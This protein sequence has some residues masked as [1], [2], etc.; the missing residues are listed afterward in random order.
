M[1][2]KNATPRLCSLARFSARWS[3]VYHSEDVEGRFGS[4]RVHGVDD[5]E[6]LAPKASSANDDERFRH[7]GS[8]P[9]P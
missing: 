1:L 8:P 4:G 5:V 6:H 7:R 3:I 2:P 9:F